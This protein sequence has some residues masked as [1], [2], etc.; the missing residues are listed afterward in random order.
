NIYLAVLPNNIPSPLAPESD[1]EGAPRPAADGGRGGRGGNAGAGG[2]P[3]EA[4][5]KPVRID[6]DKLQ[7]RIVALP[8]PTRAY[9][10]L[11]TGRAGIL[12][13]LEPGAAGG[14]GRGAAA[15]PVPVPTY[16]IVPSATPV[17]PGEG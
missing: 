4:P 10:E 3:P 9:L 7:Q 11:E 8:L 15:G 17:K 12:F 14:A 5:P 16:V 6:F 2:A 13:V 1:E